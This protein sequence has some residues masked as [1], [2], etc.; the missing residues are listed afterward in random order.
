MKRRQLEEACRD[1]VRHTKATFI[2]ERC[3]AA[4][5]D[6]R[7]AQEALDAHLLESA[8]NKRFFM[9]QAIYCHVGHRRGRSITLVPVLD[10]VGKT[11][12]IAIINSYYFYINMYSGALI[13]FLRCYI[14]IKDY[15]VNFRG[16]M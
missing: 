4:A 8:S 5:H 11:C 9:K 15:I 7:Q 6:W 1:R 16:G 12:C 14:D 10:I 13:G 2:S 3:G